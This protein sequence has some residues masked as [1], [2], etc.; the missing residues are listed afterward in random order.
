MNDLTAARPPAWFRILSILGLLWT[1]LGVLMYLI[2]VRIIEGGEM[3]EAQRALEASVP[4][5]VTAA[6]A[7]AVFAGL[8][9]ALGLVLLKRWAKPLLVLSLIAVLLQEG[10]TIFVSDGREVHGAAGIAMPA[11][12]VLVAILLVWLAN[13]GIRRGWLS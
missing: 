11:L 1:L 10:W 4:P 7:V 9:G 3:T 5:W 6:F 2:H 13:G 8:L 12:I